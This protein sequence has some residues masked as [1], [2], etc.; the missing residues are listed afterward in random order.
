M[1]TANKNLEYKNGKKKQMYG[2]FKREP[3]KIADEITW[4]WLR[5]KNLKQKMK[6]ISLRSTK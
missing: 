6:K 5:R 4:T 1:K 3:K 2:Y